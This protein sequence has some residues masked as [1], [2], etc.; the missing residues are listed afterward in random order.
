[1]LDG[2]L[3]LDDSALPSASATLTRLARR[4]P[5]LHE[6]AGL[7]RQVD[8]HLA[9]VRAYLGDFVF[10]YAGYVELLEGAQTER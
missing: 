4:H 8:G 3:A 10:W 9:Q 6:D 2:R 1:M 5:G 7:Q